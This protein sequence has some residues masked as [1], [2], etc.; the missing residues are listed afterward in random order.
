MAKMDVVIWR[1]EFCVAI[2]ST[3]LASKMKV[4]KKIAS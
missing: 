1:W 4:E 2:A 3:M